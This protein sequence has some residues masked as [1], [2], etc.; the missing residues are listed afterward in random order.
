MEIN[1]KALKRCSLFYGLEKEELEKIIRL[2]YERTFDVGETIFNHLEEGEAFYFIHQG[3]VRISRNSG[4]QMVTIAELSPGHVLGEMSL[5]SN[6]PRTADGTAIEKTTL[7]ELTR[8]R[9]QSLAHLE[10]S[11][12]RKIILNISRILCLR[13]NNATIRVSEVL[14]VLIEAESAR[15]SLRER[16]EKSKAGLLGFLG[17]LGSSD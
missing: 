14:D 2:F 8:K 11:I 5:I 16:V 17:A 6:E 7:W 4:S 9:F 13:L 1:H 12:Y 10:P 15:T 3:R